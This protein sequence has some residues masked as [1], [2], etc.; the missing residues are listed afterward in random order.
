MLTLIETIFLPLGVLTGYFGMN[1][2]SMGGHVGKGHEPA[3]GILG[4]KYGQGFVWLIMGVCTAMILYS[5]DWSKMEHFSNIKEVSDSFGRTIEKKN[6]LEVEEWSDAM[7]NKTNVR[8]F[9]VNAEDLKKLRNK[10]LPPMEYHWSKSMEP[11]DIPECNK[12]K[13]VP[14]PGSNGLMDFPFN[15]I[16]FYRQGLR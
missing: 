9:N 14:K 11:I 15:D 6:K 1:F 10:L 7:E 3:P 5:F 12:G 8:P 16:N 13:R 4:L 2:S